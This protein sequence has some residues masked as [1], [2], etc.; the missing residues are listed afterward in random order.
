MK[1]YYVNTKNDRINFYDYPYLFQEADLLDYALDYTK[2]VRQNYN[3]I[4]GAKQQIQERSIKLAVIE[5]F[6]IAYKERK[7]LYKKAVNRLYEVLNYDVVAGKYGKICTDTGFYLKCQ[8]LGST[9][10]KWDTKA[11][12]MYNTLKVVIP[13]YIW[14][15]EQSYHFNS[16]GIVSSNNKAYPGKY[17]YRYANGLNTSY[18]INPHFA[19]SNFKMIIYGPAVNP[20][21]NIGSNQY[22]VYIILEEGENLEIDSRTGTIEKVLRNGERVNAFHNR[23]K[24]TKFFKKISSGRQSISFSSQMIFDLFI[25]EERSEPKW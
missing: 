9:K 19:D 14:I 15:S 11:P 7:E 21:I 18:I 16:T 13:N 24:G 3:S 23:R 22:L 2:V 20:Q 12:F 25:Y 10:D 6:K 5:D 1:F 17:R 4:I 8:I